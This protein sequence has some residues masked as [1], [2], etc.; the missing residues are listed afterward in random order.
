MTKYLLFLVTL[1]SILGCDR[2]EINSPPVIVMETFPFVGDSLTPF[3]FDLRKSKDPEDLSENLTMEFDW[4]SDGIYDTLIVG[5]KS[6]V[7]SFVGGGLHYVT[8]RITDRDNSSATQT[9]SLYIFPKPVFGEMIDSRDGRKYKTV[10]LSGRWWM[11]EYLKYGVAI[12]TEDDPTDNG[13]TEF[14]YPENNSENFDYYG[15]LYTWQEAMGYNFVESSQGACPT[16]WHIP[17]SE[18]WELLGNGIPSIFLSYYY[19]PDG[20]GGLDLRNA[21]VF[22]I[23]IEQWEVLTERYSIPVGGHSSFWSSTFFHRNDG[24]S[25][26]EAIREYR[27]G[28]ELISTEELAYDPS[29]L[30][31]RSN[32]DRF[33]ISGV[34]HLDQDLDMPYYI[35]AKSIRCVKNR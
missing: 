34:L 23:Y 2:S 24:H 12:D 8:G 10:Y 30:G 31:F 9:D 25:G 11:A 32:A 4:E 5:L 22:L 27:R 28:F 6:V 33:H 17:S 35:S 13:L 15:G 14:Y 1:L 3:H 18:E 29:K 21:G 19:G 7:H 20:P 16:G 26:N